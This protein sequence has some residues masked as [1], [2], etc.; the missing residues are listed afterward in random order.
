MAADQQKQE[1]ESLAEKKW[2]VEQNLANESQETLDKALQALTP[3][4]VK[5]TFASGYTAGHVAD[6][7]DAA[8]DDPNEAEKRAYLEKNGTLIAK[9]D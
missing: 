4:P 3:Q 6:A 7:M 1:G 8:E 9:P 2:N 5:K